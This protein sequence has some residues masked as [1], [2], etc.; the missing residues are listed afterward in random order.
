MTRTLSEPPQTESKGRASV[1]GMVGRVL[2]SLVIL[3][4][5]F[6]ITYV[7]A[8][9]WISTWVPPG[10]KQAEPYPATNSCLIPPRRILW[11]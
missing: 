9:P 2:L 11:P 1:K 6:A 7:L 5:V 8:R 10:R 4:A 3:S